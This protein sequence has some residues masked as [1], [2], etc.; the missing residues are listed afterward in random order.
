MRK[1]IDK[2][3][4]EGMMKS[5]F[6]TWKW[7]LVCRLLQAK[8]ENISEILDNACMHFSILDLG[9]SYLQIELDPR[10]MCKIAFS[11]DRSLWI[12]VYAIWT[13]NESSTFQRVMDSVLKDWIGYCKNTFFLRYF[14]KFIKDYSNIT[15][16]IH[17]IDTD[18]IPYTNLE[19][20]YYYSQDYYV[21]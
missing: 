18:N 19:E 2:N 20:Y 4:Q 12:C 1:L 6:Y 15:W 9:S 3:L 16:I 8:W 7:I 5:S 11:I 17:S 21:Q 10:D 13:K 14:R